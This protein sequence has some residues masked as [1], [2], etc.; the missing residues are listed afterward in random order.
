MRY[1]KEGTPKDY[2]E[3]IRIKKAI[4]EETKPIQEEAKPVQEETQENKQIHEGEDKKQEQLAQPVWIFIILV[5]SKI[6]L[7]HSCFIDSK[8]LILAAIL[9]IKLT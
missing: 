7:H 8:I 9:S 6:H 1:W 2:Q 4:Q 3:G 5:K